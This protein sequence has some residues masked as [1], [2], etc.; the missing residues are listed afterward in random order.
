MTGE[1]LYPKYFCD[2]RG[3]HDPVD[4]G[5]P[6]PAGAELGFEDFHPREVRVLR[7]G[8]AV[9]SCPQCGRELRVSGM[10]LRTAYRSSLR[11]INISRMPF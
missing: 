7:W 2:G 11:E 5:V 6:P 3:T 9:F 4:L 8:H 10:Q 1:A